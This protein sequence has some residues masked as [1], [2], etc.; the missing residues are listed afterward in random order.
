MAATNQEEKLKLV[1]TQE[2]AG[3]VIA[4]GTEVITF[5]LLALSRRI[6]EIEQRQ[7]PSSSTPSGMIPPYK[8]PRA[9]K[10]RKKPG[11][12][13]GHVGSRRGP[14]PK[15]DRTEDHCLTQCPHCLSSRLYRISCG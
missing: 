4:Q 6:Q 3:A 5:Y 8:K 10:R 1:M 2:E 13:P 14:P 12:K 9:P 7:T 11:R 15:V